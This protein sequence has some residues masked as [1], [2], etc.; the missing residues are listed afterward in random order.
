MCDH[1]DLPAELDSTAIIMCDDEVQTC[2]VLTD[3]EIIQVHGGHGMKT[4]HL[5]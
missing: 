2:D 1:I 3:Q 4:S 5:C